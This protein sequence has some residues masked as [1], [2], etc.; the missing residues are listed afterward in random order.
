MD[1]FINQAVN[2]DYPNNWER[3]TALSNLYPEIDH[4]Y[5]YRNPSFFLSTEPDV[6][7]LYKPVIRHCRPHK[8]GGYFDYIVK[9]QFS[10]LRE[11]AIDAG[12]SLDLVVWGVNRQ[13]YR[14]ALPIAEL[15]EKLGYVAPMETESPSFDDEL[16]TFLEKM[17]I[18]KIGLLKHIVASLD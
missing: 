5:Y 15:L 3:R 10:T 8:K 11:W 17:N 6:Q 4:V 2:I 14:F 18:S 7:D 16:S 13:G 9:K 1:Q 12:G